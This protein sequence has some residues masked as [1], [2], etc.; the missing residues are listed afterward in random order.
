MK[1]VLAIYPGSF[2]PVTNGHLDLIERGCHIVSGE[3]NGR[4]RVGALRPAPGPTPEPAIDARGLG[5]GPGADM[6]AF[7]AAQRFVTDMHRTI[8]HFRN[9]GHFRRGAGGHGTNAIVRLAGD[10]L[11]PRPAPQSGDPPSRVTEPSTSSPRPLS[12]ITR[13]PQRHHPGP[14]TSSPGPRP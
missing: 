7:E 14:S 4:D 10:M 8:I 13:A 6:Q 9:A 5:R 3:I 1:K 12:V 2:D 11:E